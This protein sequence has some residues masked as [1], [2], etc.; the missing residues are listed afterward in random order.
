MKNSFKHIIRASLLT[1][2]AAGMTGCLEETFPASATITADQIANADKSYLASAI[3]A[4]FTTYSSDYY[5]DTGFSSFGHWR[6]AMSA[7]FPIYDSGYDYFYYYNT[8]TYLGNYELQTVFWRRY[9]YLL[10]KCNSVIPLCDRNPDGADALNLGMAL[11]YRAWVYMDLMRTYEYK[12]TGVARLD[13]YAESNGLYGLTVPLITENTTEAES[14]HLPRAHFTQMYRF[15][16]NDLNEAEK[17][18]AGH[19]TVGAKNLVSRGV[20]YGMKARLWL[21]MGSRFEKYAEDLQQQLE[22]E[23]DGAYV[24]LDKLGITT[25]NDCFANAA[26]YARKAINDGYRPLSES[27]WYDPVNGFNT[28]VS[29]WMLCIIINSNNG[30]AK[31]CTWQSM[32]SFQSPEATYGISTKEYGGYRMIDAR[33]YS[34]MNTND[35]RRDTWINPD[36]VG[37]RSAF[38]SKYAKTTSMAFDEWQEYTAYAG[39]KFHPAQGARDVSTTGNAISIPLMR[40]EEMYLIEAEAAAHSEGPGAGKALLE[41]FM[42][43][44]R[45]KSGKTFTCRESSLDGVV[46]EIF[47]QKRIELW[48]EGLILWDYRRLEKAIERGYPG[49][50]HPSLYRYNSYADNV[51]PWTNFYIPD[52][53]NQLNPLCKLN[54]DPSNAIPTLWKE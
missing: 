46:N 42:N 14:R 33:L 10:Q 15:I 28:P 49:T 54:P 19:Q 3:P 24:S 27:E 41:T 35:W 50:N 7:D 21:E 47:R 12:K 20:V 44:Y 32:V 1:V 11:T 36:D 6:D 48:G 18:L 9:Y 2:F 23:N 13:D 22:A 34:E 39:F 31:S 52:R 16:M 25:A 51:A 30:L 45:M 43:S 4:Y 26:A 5:W 38:E 37:S 40:I 8:Q 29:S 53:V 17:L